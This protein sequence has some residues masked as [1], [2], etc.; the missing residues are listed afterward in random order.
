MSLKIIKA[1]ILDTIQDVGRNGYRHLGINPSGAMDRLSAQLANAL[2]GKELNAPVIEMHFPASHFLFQKTTVVCLTGADF[3]ATIS[4]KTIPL[5]QPVLIPGGSILEFKRLTTG[6]HCYLALLH[7]LQGDEWLGSSSTNLKAMAGGHFGR[8]LEKED[9]IS[10]RENVNLNSVDDVNEVT[11]LHWKVFPGH[12]NEIVEC[13]KGPEWEWF[14]GEAQWNFQNKNF[15]ISNLSDRMGYRLFGEELEA[16]KGK[17]MIS[18]AVGFGTVQ[19]LPNGQLIILMA[20]HQTTGGYPRVAHVCA[21]SLPSLAQSK[22]GNEI[23]FR[24]ISIGDAEDK[25]IQ[26]QKYLEQL[27]NACKLKMENFLHAL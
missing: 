1:G 24:F 14:N 23:S 17:E 2:L 8:R 22:P 3:S 6:A 7:N 18:S 13:I 11:V 25:L 12:V 27:Q 21:T 9:V 15:T 19:L 10:F 5:H 16:E 4:N 26:Q 20:D